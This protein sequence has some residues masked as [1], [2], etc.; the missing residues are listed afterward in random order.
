MGLGASVCCYAKFAIAEMFISEAQN[1]C[2][3]K[4]RQDRMFNGMF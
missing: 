4:A 2:A 3:D 1:L